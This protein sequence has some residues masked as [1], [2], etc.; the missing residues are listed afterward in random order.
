MSISRA[1]S[2]VL[3]EGLIEELYETGTL[4][5]DLK[6]NLYTVFRETLLEALHII[7][8]KSVTLVKSQ[9]SGRMVFK[10]SEPSDGQQKIDARR[11]YICLIYPRYCSCEFFHQNVILEKQAILCKHSLAA[12]LG[13]ILDEFVLEEM[14]DEAFAEYYYEAMM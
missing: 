9:P 10:V 6:I 3:Y 4:T 5:D 14:D 12:I 11:N 8:T 2:N 13:N 7:D 1:N